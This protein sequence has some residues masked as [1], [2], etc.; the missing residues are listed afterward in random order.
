MRDV[1]LAG[2]ASLVAAGVAAPLVFKML[3][4][5]K[6]RQN[7]SAHL[8][9]HAH[10]QGTPT[11]GGIIVL[12]GLLAGLACTWRPEFLGLVVLILG[13]A[14]VGFADDYV[15]PKLKPGSR[16]LSW[17]PKLGMEIAAAI[18]GATLS[19]WSDPVQVGMFVFLVLFL[20]NAYNF[21]DGL[22]TLAGGL[23][24]VLCLGFLLWCVGFILNPSFEGT[25]PLRFGVIALVPV[26]TAALGVGFLPFLFY[27]APPARVFMGDVGALPI[28]AVFGWITMAVLYPVGGS[29]VVDIPSL[30][31][32]VVMLGVMFIEIVPVPIQIFWVKVFKKRAFTFKTP[33]HHAFQ[34][35]GWPETRIVWMFHVVQAGLVVVALAI[36]ELL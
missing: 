2:I 18:L 11:M 15:V 25:S 19:G 31:P 13:F 8:A 16:G 36:R 23:G 6:S 30:L 34:E 17:M 7:V 9:E 32:L 14:A 4:A 24:V 21:S 33:V 28:G 12:I 10:K 1:A 35:R 3:L 5:L 20:S 27:N 22:D 29:A 26:V